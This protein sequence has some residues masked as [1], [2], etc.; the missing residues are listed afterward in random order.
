MQEKK[1]NKRLIL[2]LSARIKQISYSQLGQGLTLSKHL[3]IIGG[4]LL[5]VT[6]LLP[7]LWI[8]G[9]VILILPS[10]VY[11]LDWMHSKYEESLEKKSLFDKSRES[12]YYVEKVERKRDAIS[13]SRQWEFAR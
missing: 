6:L 3:W 7:L 9:L 11:L 1:H 12:D 4:M 10:E 8:P 5:A 2:E 13:R